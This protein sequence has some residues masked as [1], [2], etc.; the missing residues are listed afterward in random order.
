MQLSCKNYH[1]KVTLQLFIKLERE[2][3]EFNHLKKE[4]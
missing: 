1:S 2:Q 3:L 4:E